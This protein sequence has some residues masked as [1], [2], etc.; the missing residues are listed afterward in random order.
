MAEEVKFFS[1]GLYY[2]RYFILNETT[3][4]LLMQIGVPSSCVGLLAS[5]LL[6]QLSLRRSRVE[7]RRLSSELAFSFWCFVYHQQVLEP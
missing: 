4:T 1:I 6:W 5:I 7:L 2:K 3:K